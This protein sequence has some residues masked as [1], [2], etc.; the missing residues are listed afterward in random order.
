MAMH[1]WLAV[2]LEPGSARSTATTMETCS[3]PN[4]HISVTVMIVHYI[5]IPG[6]KLEI[7]F[8]VCWPLDKCSFSAFRHQLFLCFI[9]IMENKF[10]LV[11]FPRSSFYHSVRILQTNILAKI[12]NKAQI[13]TL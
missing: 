7:L 1:P 8:T 3:S 4:S 2:T 13:N 10:E 5:L 12:L 6:E 9:C 11:S